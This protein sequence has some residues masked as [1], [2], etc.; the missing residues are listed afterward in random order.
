MEGHNRSLSAGGGCSGYASSAAT[1]SQITRFLALYY[2]V[3]MLP[4]LSSM[5]YQDSKGL[6]SWV[7]RSP[8]LAGYWTFKLIGR[9]FSM[10]FSHDSI[11]AP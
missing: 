11:T 2:L 7:D 3:W 5:P 1:V 10:D 9:G 8:L 6:N 4:D